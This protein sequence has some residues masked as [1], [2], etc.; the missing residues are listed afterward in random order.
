MQPNE[1]ISFVVKGEPIAMPRPRFANGRAY[2]DKGH[3]V[4]AWKQQV[5]LACRLAFAGLEP[6]QG[7]VMLSVTFIM[8]R[9]KKMCRAHAPA[10][11]VYHTSKPDTD[12]LIK[13]VKDAMTGVA[14]DDDAQV[15]CEWSVKFYQAKV[16]DEPRA[17]VVLGPPKLET[18]GMQ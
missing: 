10:G 9:P 14:Y 7:P 1:H 11:R 18:G 16:D 3:A 12:N 5:N 13:A 2:N 17:Y 15:C 8:P 6:M 4:Q